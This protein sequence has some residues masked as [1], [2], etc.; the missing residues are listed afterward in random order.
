VKEKQ[1][2][3]SPTESPLEICNNHQK[4]TGTVQMLLKSEKTTVAKIETNT[5][6]NMEVSHKRKQ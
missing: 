1:I 6:S 5:I 4:I 3:T 2:K